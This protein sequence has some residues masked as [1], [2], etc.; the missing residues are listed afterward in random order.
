MVYVEDRAEYLPESEVPPGSRLLTLS[1][2]EFQR[3]MQAGLKIPDW[4]SFP[5]VLAELHRQNPPRERQGGSGGSRPGT[6]IARQVRS[7]S[8]DTLRL[9]CEGRCRR[10]RQAKT[11]IATRAPKGAWN[12]VARYPHLGKT[13]GDK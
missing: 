2:E 4:Y 12:P 10:R 13:P 3:R 1:G 7:R 8:G 6:H 5:E 9:Q 11:A